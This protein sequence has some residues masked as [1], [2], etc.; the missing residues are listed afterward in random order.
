MGAVAGWSQLLQLLALPLSITRWKY[1]WFFGDAVLNALHVMVLVS[2][3]VM[4]APG[5]GSRRYVISKQLSQMSGL[6]G[7]EDS[8]PSSD[9]LVTLLSEAGK[10]HQTTAQT[11]G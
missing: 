3:M 5:D 11:I 2:V 4:W 10:S 1:Y 8:S 6:E 7:D 9:S